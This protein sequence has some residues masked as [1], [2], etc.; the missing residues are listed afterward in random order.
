MKMRVVLTDEL[1]KQW[2]GELVLLKSQMP[3]IEAK[4]GFEVERSTL[5]FELGERAFARA[6]A[7]R[8]SG[9]E[10]LTLLIAY[11]AKGEVGKA[12]RINE[13]ESLWGRMTSVLGIAY[14]G[15]Y[16]TVAKEYGWVNAQERGVYVLTAT[17]ASAVG[18]SKVA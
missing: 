17:W 10:I 13:V 16:P 2:S 8:R 5:E 4:P 14:N 7:F 9:P 1:G 18:S 15:K 3:T 12:V 11:L 6:Y